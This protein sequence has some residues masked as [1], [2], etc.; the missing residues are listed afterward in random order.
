MPAPGKKKTPI[1]KY[2]K[3]YR[4]FECSVTSRTYLTWF[5]RSAMIIAQR[6]P[7]HYQSMTQILQNT[8]DVKPPARQTLWFRK[9]FASD[10]LFREKLKIRLASPRHKATQARWR[11]NHPDYNKI[12]RSQQPGF[13]P[14]RKVG[15]PRKNP[16]Q[17]SH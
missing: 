14:G 8:P 11:K 3:P 7:Q 2:D 15:R 1:R 4:G 17:L 5:P 16:P 9:K 12:W 13:V 6:K 10:P